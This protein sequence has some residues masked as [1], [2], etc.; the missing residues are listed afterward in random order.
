MKY[1]TREM[2]DEYKAAPGDILNLQKQIEISSE[3]AEILM[4]KWKGDLFKATL[5]AFK[6]SDGITSVLYEKVNMD[7]YLNDNTLG[8]EDET[9]THRK[10]E[11]ARIISDE[12]DS[13][14]NDSKD[15]PYETS[16]LIKFEYIPFNYDTELFLRKSINTDKYNMETNTIE[17]YLLDTR[18]EELGDSNVVP[19]FL[20]GKSK[21]LYKKWSL[22]DP[23]IFFLKNHKIALGISDFDKYENRIGTSLLRKAGHLLDNEILV[24][25]CVVVDNWFLAK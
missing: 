1:K 16:R 2:E 5:D 12:K 3:H 10:L 24:G 7:L 8:I 25:S 17:K 18:I 11:K 9:N 6:L 23:A 19:R 21:K 13:I 20:G 4:N 15:D 14:L 22:T